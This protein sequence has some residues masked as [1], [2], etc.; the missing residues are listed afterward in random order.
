MAILRIAFFDA[1]QYEIDSFNDA[2]ATYHFDIKYFQ[3]RLSEN[4]V[5]ITKQADAVCAFVND[6]IDD[7]VAHALYDN[8]ITLIALRSAGYNNVDFQAVF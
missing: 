3:S 5:I 2:N 4:N 7:K 1:K 8:G 6:I